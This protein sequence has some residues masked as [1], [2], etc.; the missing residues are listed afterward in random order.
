VQQLVSRIVEY[1][2]SEVSGQIRLNILTKIRDNA[3]NNY[4]RAWLENISAM[5]ITRDWLKAGAAVN[6][7]NQVLE[8]VMPLLHV[9]FLRFISILHLIIFSLRYLSSPADILSNDLMARDGQIADRLPF[10][11]DTL[12]SSKIGKIVRKLAKDAPI[13]GEY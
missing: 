5:D 6:A 10:T 7:D 12:V 9:C 4:F 2:I 1:G 3:G 11:G 8:T 13:P